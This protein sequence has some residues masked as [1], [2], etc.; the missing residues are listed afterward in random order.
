M[1]IAELPGAI[2]E[3]VC[4]T[5]VG[6]ELIIDADS[7]TCQYHTTVALPPIDP[8]SMYISIKKTALLK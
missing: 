6:N 8:G 4:F 5:E 3:S 2:K 1:V 7:G